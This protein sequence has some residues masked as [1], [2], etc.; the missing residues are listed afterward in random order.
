VLIGG[1]VGGATAA[2]RLFGENLDPD[3]VSS[4][5]GVQPTLAYRKG[6][7]V[8]TRSEAR[9]KQGM[10][11][12]ESALPESKSLEEHINSVLSAIQCSC[13]L[14]ERVTGNLS[15]D[16]FCGLFV[17]S[18]SSGVSLSAAVLREVVQRGL[19]I[20]VDLVVRN[21]PENSDPGTFPP[22]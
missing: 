8:S 19:S 7:R 12:I 14:W 13:E 4:Q 11:Q 21:G 1:E 6:D 22:A 2:L 5:L 17:E 15:R 3:A 16:I 20:E 9:R 10:W 18:Q